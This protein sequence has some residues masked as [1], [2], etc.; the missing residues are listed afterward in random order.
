MM[1]ANQMLHVEVA[2]KDAKALKNILYNYFNQIPDRMKRPE[3]YAICFLP[4]KSQAKTGQG[5]K[6]KQMRHA[7]LK[8]HQTIVENLCLIRSSDIQDLNGYTKWNGQTWSLRKFILGL[9]TDLLDT[10]STVFLFHSVDYAES[11]D[12][13][14]ANIVYF[15]AF[16]DRE[17][18]AEAVVDILPSLVQ[19][20]L[21]RSM[22]V[23]WFTKG[24]LQSIDEPEWLGM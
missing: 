22:A 3:C 17:A 4:D 18:K 5:S 20:Q 23:K 9:R 7:A 15:T 10:T 24:V 2:R 8:K 12:D 14:E 1:Q 16:K 11:G 21:D 6:N 13:A 19:K